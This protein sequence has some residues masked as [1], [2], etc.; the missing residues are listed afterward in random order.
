MPSRPV[1]H[2]GLCILVCFGSG[3]PGWEIY[4]PCVSS[5]LTHGRRDY[6]G[7]VHHERVVSFDTLRAKLPEAITKDPFCARLA[8]S[9]ANERDHL[10]AS[11]AL[12]YKQLMLI[13]YY[14]PSGNRV[15]MAFETYCLMQ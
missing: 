4:T 6:V 14:S 11:L 3:S 9:S 1:S 7:D 10:S 8:P 5:G 15:L 12:M 2:G 13:I